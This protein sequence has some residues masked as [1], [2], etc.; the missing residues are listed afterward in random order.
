MVFFSNYYFGWYLAIFNNVEELLWV[1]TTPLNFFKGF[2][3]THV[4]FLGPL[5]PL[6]WISGDD[7]SGF[8]SQIGFCLTH[9]LRFRM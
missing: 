7:L 8:Q 9:F 6:F 5:V 4:L 1:L 2:W 3:Q